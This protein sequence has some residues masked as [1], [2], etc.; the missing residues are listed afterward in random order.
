MFT[1]P[2]PISLAMNHP[3]LLLLK[4]RSHLLVLLMVTVKPMDKQE[5]A[6]DVAE[7][8][9]AVV[10]AVLARP[11]STMLLQAVNTLL[12]AMLLPMDTLMVSFIAVVPVAVVVD[13][14]AEGYLC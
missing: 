9:E 14:V 4:Q 10:V 12:L 11:E 3:L 8:A 6:E 5:D 7:V 1:Y 2:V 13:L